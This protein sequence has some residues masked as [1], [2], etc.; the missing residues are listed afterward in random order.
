MCNT[1]YSELARLKLLKALEIIHSYAE[2]GAKLLYCDTDS[3]IFQYPFDK[4]DDMKQDLGVKDLFGHLKIEKKGHE[5]LEYLSGGSKQ[6]ALKVYQRKI[7]YG[8]CLDA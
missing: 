1:F 4:W 3:V 8:N 6:Y 5:I 2:F 7:F